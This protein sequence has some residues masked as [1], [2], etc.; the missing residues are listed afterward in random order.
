M[1][2]RARALELTE[3]VADVE[4]TRTRRRALAADLGGLGR[5]DEAAALLKGIEGLD[6]DIA[7][8]RRGEGLLD[9]D[10]TYQQGAIMR[11]GAAS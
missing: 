2:T 5:F 11:R 9:A 10:Y 8:L 6:E 1:A 7:R 3:K 4:Q